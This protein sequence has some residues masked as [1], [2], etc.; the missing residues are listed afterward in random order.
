MERKIRTG[1]K[2]KV[3]NLERRKCGMGNDLVVLSM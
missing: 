3:I 2:A 1:R